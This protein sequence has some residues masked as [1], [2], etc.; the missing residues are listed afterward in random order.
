MPTATG[1]E[2]IGERLDRLRVELTRVRATIE[3]HETN[4]ASFAIGGA[5][6][7]QV[8]YDRALARC[9]RLE[10]QIRQLEARLA[11][12]PEGGSALFQVHHKAHN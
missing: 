12:S 5:A 4:G 11:G 9:A 8:A 1:S 3:R 6:V 7:T 10:G 2:T